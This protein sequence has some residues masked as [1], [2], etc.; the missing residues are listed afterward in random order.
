MIGKY[1]NENTS[2]EEF[3]KISEQLINAKLD[4]DKKKTWKQ[5]LQ[6]EYK[7]YRKA[8]PTKT[9]QRKLFPWLM[10]AAVAI[11]LGVVLFLIFPQA[12]QNPQQLA[13]RYIQDL[14][15]MA[16]QTSMR[17]GM[18]TVGEI[19]RAANLTYSEQAYDES[20]SLWEQLI[21]SDSVLGTDYLYLGLC[22]LKKTEA[23][24]PKSIELFKKART[25][26][27]SEEE[28]DWVLALAYLQVGDLE[29]GRRELSKII[30][31]QQYQ[32][33]KAIKLMKAI[34]EEGE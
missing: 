24:P 18:E 5:K 11:L 7:V 16:D 32:A 12:D 22:H 17:K 29:A 10:A 34:E 4:R 2:E 14:S 9:N 31:N 1:T 25:F 23:E 15:I 21:E 28:V 26:K 19:R 6:D 20:I 33:M 27:V 30:D 8:N 13:Q 3:E